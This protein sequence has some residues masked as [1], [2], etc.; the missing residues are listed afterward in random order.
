MKVT[1]VKKRE[2]KSKRKAMIKE[3]KFVAESITFDNNQAER[4]EKAQYCSCKH[5]NQ[6][7]NNKNQ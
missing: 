7:V 3:A 5:D 4:E 6:N 1:E 2:F